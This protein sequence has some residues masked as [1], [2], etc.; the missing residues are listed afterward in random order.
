MKNYLEN[1]GKRYRWMFLGVGVALALVGG[2][3]TASI[4]GAIVGIPMLLLAW[5]LLKSPGIP[6]ACS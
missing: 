2:I 3:F 6:V 1:C 5:P 4:V